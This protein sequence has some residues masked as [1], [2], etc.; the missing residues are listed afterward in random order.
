MLL[1]AGKTEISASQ[2]GLQKYTTEYRSGYTADVL[3]ILDEL[4]MDGETTRCSVDVI[5]SFDHRASKSPTIYKCLVQDKDAS[6]L[7][8]PELTTMVFEM[9]VTGI[10]EPVLLSFTSNPPLSS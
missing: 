5:M 3:L 9:G 8:I 1:Q 2:F 7:N 10:Q 4:I 6:Y